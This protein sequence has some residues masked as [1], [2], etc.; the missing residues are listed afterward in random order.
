MGF[1]ETTSAG[2]Q[3]I[4]QC[5]YDFEDTDRGRLDKTTLLHSLLSDGMEILGNPHRRPLA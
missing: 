1:L 2:W 4:R 3:C 5:L